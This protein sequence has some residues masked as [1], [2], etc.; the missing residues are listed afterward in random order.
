MATVTDDHP[1]AIRY[2]RNP[3]VVGARLGADEMALLSAARGKYYGLNG[4]A[5]R[6][7][8]L[9]ARASSVEEICKVLLSE[10]DV[11]PAACERETRELIA[12]LVGEGLVSAQT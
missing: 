7:W 10:F 1:I 3:A 2:A 4:S 9:L 8:E 12:E 11:E 6:I 5:T